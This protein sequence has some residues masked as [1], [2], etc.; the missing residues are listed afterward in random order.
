MLRPTFTIIVLSLLTVLLY[1]P[2]HSGNFKETSIQNRVLILTAHPDDECLF[3]G[4]TIL[5]LDKANTEIYS[6]SLSTGNA[7]GLG[8]IRSHEYHKSYEALGVPANRRWIVDHPELQDNITASWDPRT[9]SQTIRPY[10]ISNSINTILTFDYAGVSSHPNHISLPYGVAHLIQTL[11][12]LD[13]PIPRLY[14]LTTV[15]TFAKYTS[16]VAPLVAKLDLVL[17]QSFDRLYTIS[18]LGNPAS[19]RIPQTF[20]KEGIPSSVSRAPIFV[21]GIS[22]YLRALKAM[23]M[24]HSQL[25]WFRWLYVLFS[26]YMWVNDWLEVQLQ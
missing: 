20:A 23:R 17:A 24:H 9:I 2:L 19:D 3:F 6:L 11:Y 15:P 13:E 4:P 1:S 5:A 25:V 12:A 26:R 8:A 16:I 14:T 7:D 22:E 10:V 18:G 21:S